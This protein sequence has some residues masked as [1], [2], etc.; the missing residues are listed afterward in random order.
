MSSIR[1]NPLP[2]LSQLREQLLLY[3]NQMIQ[4]ETFTHS[5]FEEVHLTYQKSARNLID[6]LSIRSME[7]R[8]V[9]EGLHELGLSSLSG[10]EI[11]IRSQIETV[12]QR[13]E[14]LMGK[15]PFGPAESDP[16]VVNYEKGKSLL[17]EHAAELLGTQADTG[18]VRI[19]VTMPSEAATD[20]ELVHN[21]MANGMNLA[22]INLAHD[23]ESAWLNMIQ[24]IKQ[25]EQALNKRCKVYMDLAGP[26]L[27]T[28]HV[29]MEINK[30]GVAKGFRL[31][32]GDIIYFHKSPDSKAAKKLADTSGCMVLGTTL[33]QIFEDVMAGERLFLDDGKFAGV[34]QQ[35]DG[36]VMRVEILHTPP[37]GARLKPDKGINLPD[38][39]L[40]TPS[41]TE[42]DKSLIPF[43]CEH[44]DIVGYSF[45][46]S[47][48]DIRE[49]H[50]LLLDHQQ[51]QL[52]GMVIKIELGKAVK[53]LP[54]LLLAGM[55]NPRFGVMIARGDLAVEIG[56]ERLSEIQEEILWL[57]TAGHV[58]VIWATQVLE[59][60]AKEGLPSRSEVSDASQAAKADCVMLNKGPNIIATVRILDDILTRMIGHMNTKRQV[61][62]PLRIAQRFVNQVQ[63]DE[64]LSPGQGK[65]K[66]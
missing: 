52:P 53:D 15:R 27:R 20:Y 35:N 60:L 8:V 29:P 24:H 58:P 9:Q 54:N 39:I 30:K 44:A 46:R 45:V 42:R 23:D 2:T 50:Q 65:P 43:V 21:L 7:L 37:M 13:I 28:T 63:S 17:A 59:R 33:N 38:S 6:Y 48:D 14:E 40:S 64:A 51:K 4:L 22:R 61:M 47:A 16:T 5:K 31:M 25:A 66:K 41:L 49:L 1:Q 10:C 55:V 26:K 32:E 62:R 57:C 34:V 12:C 3:R 36:E 56:F 11:H 18:I 19:M